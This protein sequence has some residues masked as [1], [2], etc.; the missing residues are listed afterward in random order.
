MQTYPFIAGRFAV[1]LTMQPNSGVIADYSPT[2]YP[3]TLTFY[4]EIA[5]AFKSPLLPVILEIKG[6]SVTYTLP[7]LL[8]GIDM[9]N[10]TSFTYADTSSSSIIT[11][12]M[13]WDAITRTYT[14]TPL[15]TTPLGTY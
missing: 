5:P 2:S 13:T 1:D 4:I 8:G 15:R 12:I 3:K 14:F 9:T 7:E 10:P 6:P 11:A